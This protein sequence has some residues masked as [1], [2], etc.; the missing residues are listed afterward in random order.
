MASRSFLRALVVGAALAAGA[1]THAAV[2][3]QAAFQSAAVIN[4]N[5]GNVVNQQIGAKYAAQ[6]LANSTLCGGIIAST[7]PA[8]ASETLSNF[9]GQCGPNQ[10]FGPGELS[11][12]TTVVRVG[13]D[14]TTNP[15][16]DT[17]VTA[18]LGNT[19]VGS[20]T[21]DTFGQ[22]NGGSFAGIEFLSGF[23]RI[24]ILAD[25]TTTGAFSIDN[26]RFD[27][28]VQAVP[29]P[30]SLALMGLGLGLVGI[31]AMHKRRQV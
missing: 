9:F 13:F 26:L 3:T 5:D 18:Y 4:F 11:F 20:E 25:D 29:E 22:G 7:G 15:L 14:I 17:T 30:G 24:V 21:F 12:T 31:A 8:A 6:G 2:V 1:S 23:D 27:A 10:P 28:L 19:L 16:D